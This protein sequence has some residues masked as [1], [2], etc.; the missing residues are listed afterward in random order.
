MTDLDQRVRQAFDEIAV[1]EDVKRST[2]TYIAASVSAQT[3]GSDS[4]PIESEQQA[5]EETPSFSAKRGGRHRA[6]RALVALAACLALVAVGAGCFELYRQPTAYVGID[7]NP[8]IELGLNRFGIVVEAEALNDDGRALLDAVSVTNL[9]Y[10]DALAQLTESAAFAP[11]VEEGAFVEISVTANDEHQKEEL[12]AKSDAHL[13]SMP[14]KGSCHEVDEET[15]QAAADAGMGVG[16]YRAAVELMTLDPDTTLDECSDLTMREL[17]DRVDECSGKGKH[18]SGE[19]P[20]SDNQDGGERGS[21]HGH[22]G[23]HG[24]GRHSSE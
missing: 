2:F 19:S 17:R 21:G 7:V 1:P 20:G 11:Y 22:K 23:K 5:E 13:E 10:D 9:S 4:C 24:S 3:D 16:R 12:C 6:R 18:Q 15:R 8:S 14:C